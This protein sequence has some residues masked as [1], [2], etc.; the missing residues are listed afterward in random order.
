MS[1]PAPD[2]F[3]DPAELTLREASTA[4]KTRR[5]SP[6][7]LTR[8][9]LRRIERL[10]PSVNAFITVT[11]S[12]ALTQAKQL[13]VELAQ[14][15]WR[16]PLHGIPIAL[17][18]LIDT[19][20]IRTTAASAVFTERIPSRDAEVVR[21][22]KEAG[23]IL[24]GKL[25]L[26]EFAYGGTSDVTHFGPVRNPWNLDF[27]PGGSSGGSS[28]AVAA[29]LCYGAVGTDTA[30]SIRM[31]ASCCAIVGMKPTYGRVSTRGV[32][33]LSWS[34]DHV[35]PMCRTVEDAALM[36]EAM[37]GFDPADA[38]SVDAPV[39]MYTNS[40]GESVRASRVGVPYRMYWENLDPEVGQA[41]QE[42]LGIL[43]SLCSDVIEIRLPAVDNLTIAE[44]EAYAFHQSWL[45][46]RAQLYSAPIR[47]RLFS[48]G[49]VT[50]AAYITSRRELERW[51]REIAHIFDEIDV[52]VTP[53]MPVLPV[54]VG[55]VS[56]LSLLRN[57]CAFN[58]YGI[59]AIS[60][61]CGFSSSGLPVGLQI[62][63]PHM[64]EATV[65]QVAHAYE[66]E[67]AWFNKIPDIN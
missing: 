31:P 19:A 43:E 42:A 22:L 66:R 56:D 26:H 64:G 33:P 67:S 12:E 35:G 61:P 1:S 3:Q 38:A 49:K 25:N 7:E 55:T 8:A 18:D 10:N 39:P 46:D 62:A 60:I 53:T 5:I 17:K 41:A 15:K 40:L 30:A 50:S 57:T 52:I 11:E 13:E 29:R 27:S 37:A 45:S 47:E 34:L 59:P 2:R 9:C 16:G 14:G 28:A 6:L 44:A 36:L 54:R 4:V 23:A 20:G 48:G 51:R 58:V 32:I 65:F 21:R 24:L 63:G